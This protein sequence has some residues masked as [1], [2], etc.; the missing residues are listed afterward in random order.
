[1]N[2]LRFTVYASAALLASTIA[3]AAQLPPSMPSAPAPIFNPSGPS[4]VPQAAPVPVSPATPGPPS[5]SNLAGTSQVANP[6]RS[7]F[8][9]RRVSG[10]SYYPSHP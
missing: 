4:V 2:A 7:V 9:A 6:P 10:P 8:H 1:M 5:G 3:A